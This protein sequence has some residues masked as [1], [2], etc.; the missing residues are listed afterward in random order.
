MSF[1][2]SKPSRF[3]IARRK[4]D[5]VDQLVGAFESDTVA[6]LL[7]TSPKREHGI[8]YVLAGM[9]F[10]A[11]L[12]AA[13]VHIDRVVTSVGRVVP[14]KGSMYISPFDTGIVRQVLVKPGEIVKK[15]QVL[16]ALDPTFTHADLVQL[17]ERQASDEATV[18]RLDA[19]QTGRTYTYSPTDTYQAL[20]G[21]IWQKRRQEYK[22]NVAD[23]DARI[24]GTQAQVDQYQTDSKQYEGRL[25]LAGNVEKLYEPLLEKGYVS[26]LQAMQA[27]DERTEIGRLLADAQNQMTS[28]QHTLASVKAQRDA[29]M[30]KWHSDVGTELVLARNDLDITRQSLEKAKKLSELSTLNAPADAVVL[31][32]GKISTGSIAAG[33]GQQTQNQAPL[34]T[35]VPLD[36]TVEADVNVKAADIGFISA[37][38]PVQIKLDAYRFMQHGTAKGV[39][40]AISEGS[41]TTDDNNVPV[42]P[43]FKVRVAIKEVH[44]R[45][46]PANFRLV[47]GMTVAGD[48]MVGKR[49]ILSYLLEGALRT[50]SEAMREP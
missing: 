26:K 18:G 16:A 44:L 11:I 49:T 23:F 22:S 4:S 45:N 20:Q 30:Q 38:D 13:V 32:V 40:K 8:L 28:L 29:Y 42:D 50:G 34:F 2:I 6:V 24:R 25:K 14:S 15:G 39:I 47:P 17:Q 36:S 5:S 37:G 10:V 48:I 9:M 27:T 43:Y 46:V 33:G 1:A 31:E 41:F 3:H 19:E 7:R 35:L 12:L 21:S